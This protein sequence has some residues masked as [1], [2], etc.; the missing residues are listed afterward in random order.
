[1]RATHTRSTDDRLLVTVIWERE[2]PD[3][4]A[5]TIEAVYE[6]EYSTDFSVNEARFLVPLSVTRTD[7]RVLV[8]MTIEEQRAVQECAANHAAGLTEGWD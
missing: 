1:M 8:Q 7:T 3:A 5:P 4:D 2:T 6:V